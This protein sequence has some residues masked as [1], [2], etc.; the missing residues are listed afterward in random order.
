MSRAVVMRHPTVPSPRVSGYLSGSP[1]TR[2]EEDKRTGYA[3]RGCG[4]ETGQGSSKE[5]GDEY[6]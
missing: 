3:S 6:S 4:Q 5:A 1:K 2:T